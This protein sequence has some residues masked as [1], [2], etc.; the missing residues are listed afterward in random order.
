M[1]RYK[2]F[3]DKKLFFLSGVKT[4][5]FATHVS[6]VHFYLPI[7]YTIMRAREITIKYKILKWFNCTM[8]GRGDKTILF[9]IQRVQF[10]QILQ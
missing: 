3:V 9:I 1:D 7:S 10:I 6:R 2:T 5:F 4:R 8:Q